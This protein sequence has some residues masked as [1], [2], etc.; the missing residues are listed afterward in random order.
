MLQF[1]TTTQN[2]YASNPKKKKYRN[3]VNLSRYFSGY[4]QNVGSL[5]K[6]CNK[7]DEEVTSFRLPI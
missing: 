1:I 2:V 6:I 5:R 4:C 3:P 7:E